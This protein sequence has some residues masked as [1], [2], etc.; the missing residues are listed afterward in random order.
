MSR[1]MWSLS[2]VPDVGLLAD[3]DV[4]P[5]QCISPGESWMLLVFT[6]EGDCSRPDA[7]AS[8]GEAGG[9]PRAEG[10]ARITSEGHSQRSPR[11]Q[12]PRMGP[13]CL[14]GAP[15]GG[16]IPEDSGKGVSVRLPEDWGRPRK[17]SVPRHP[18]AAS[19]ARLF[20]GSLP[21]PHPQMFLTSP[22]IFFF[23]SSLIMWA[24]QGG[25]DP[26]PAP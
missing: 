8:L 20:H 4:S 22:V 12:A 23:F 21:H 25:P 2:H 10:G 17:G 26:S 3:V 13:G 11:G 9:V 6:Q 14:V 15:L 7:W 19:A 18:I 16:H 1:A 24:P 5:S